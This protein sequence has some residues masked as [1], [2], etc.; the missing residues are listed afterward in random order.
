MKSFHLLVTAALAVP[1][2]AACN[3][4]DPELSVT[5]FLCGDEGQ[6]PDGYSCN[7]ENICEKDGNESPP[8]DAS[9]VFQCADDSQ[10]GDNDSPTSAYITGIGQ[11][12]RELSLVSLSIC[13]SS[14]RDHYRFTAD[15]E[16]L[17]LEIRAVGL[18]DRAPLQVNVL[19]AQGTVVGSAGPRPDQTQIVTLPREGAAPY[20]LARGSNYV[21]QVLAPD[22]RENNYEL[23]IK[24]CQD[25]P[26]E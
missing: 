20:Q 25:P 23:T 8:I 7:A 9:P 16:N 24:T 4:Y 21:V 17:Y 15:V 3:P 22:Q 5:P 14:D 2:F 6:C 19:N 26:C 12:T 13:P 10:L 1:A 11:S 18:A